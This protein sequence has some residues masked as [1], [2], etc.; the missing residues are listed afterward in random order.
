MYEYEIFARLLRERGITPYQVFKATGVSQST[1][2]DWKNGKS[3]PK[4][5]KLIKIAKF[6]GVSVEYLLTGEE[7]EYLTQQPRLVNNDPELTACLEELRDREDMRMLFSLAKDAKTEDV[8]Q[9][10]HLIADL[11]AKSGQA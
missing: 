1:L 3:R 2:S 11:R 7:P 5:E 9:A 4:T 6:L 8:M 10:V